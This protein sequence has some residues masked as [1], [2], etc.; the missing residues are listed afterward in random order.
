[1][2][3]DNTCWILFTKLL[4]L[5]NWKTG[6]YRGGRFVLAAH[7]N[8]K[9]STAYAALKRLR[10]MNVISMQSNSKMTS[11]HICNWVK[12]QTDDERKINDRQTNNVTIQEVRRISKNNIYVE[13]DKEKAKTSKLESK[14]S[15]KS[16][17]SSEELN[18]AHL[19]ICSLFNKNSKR[20]KLSKARRQKLKTRLSEFSKEDF[21]RVFENISKS[22]FHRGDNARGWNLTHIGCF[23]ATRGSKNGQIRLS[24]TLT[25]MLQST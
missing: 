13:L 18:H 5:V 10:K 2:A 1:M 22:S 12:Y 16:L 15:E 7:C 9:P 6:E 14:L 3:K 11:I 21:K 19:W 4:V 20:F 23:K 8:M 25:T 17:S 24:Q